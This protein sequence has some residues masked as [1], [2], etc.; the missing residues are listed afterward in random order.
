MKAARA[1]EKAILSD[2]R[3]AEENMEAIKNEPG[4]PGEV[5][6]RLQHVRCVWEV[7][8]A[9]SE[10]QRLILSKLE[11]VA[12]AEWIEE[13]KVSVE[14]LECELEADYADTRKKLAEMFGEAEA[15]SLLAGKIPYNV[16][17]RPMFRPGIRME[18]LRQ[19]ALREQIKG[20][21]CA[22]G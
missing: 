11:T 8:K 22:I 7:L 6:R 14:R 13:A 15:L 3:N 4:D 5:A 9:R 1:D 18:T 21:R 20:L 2:L 19:A 10:Q 17:N 12:H 16:V